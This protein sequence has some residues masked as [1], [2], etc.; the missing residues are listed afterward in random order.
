LR[1][2]RRRIV[3]RV[4]PCDCGLRVLAFWPAPE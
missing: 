1:S 4:I 2:G 3:T